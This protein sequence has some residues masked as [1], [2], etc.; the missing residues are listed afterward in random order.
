MSTAF[1]YVTDQRGFDLAIHSAMSVSLSQPAPCDIH[2]FC[3]RFMPEHASRLKAA[4]AGVG[5]DLTFHPISNEAVEHH[6]THGHV[7]TPTPPQTVG[8]GGAGWSLR[9]TGLPRQ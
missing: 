8:R 9:S 5:A 2:V 3:Y 7:T 4:M 1:L 6:T